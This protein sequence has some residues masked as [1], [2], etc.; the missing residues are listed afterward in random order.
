MATARMAFAFLGEAGLAEVAA[1]TLPGGARLR[2]GRPGGAWVDVVLV[3]RESVTAWRLG[4]HDVPEVLHPGELLA[5]NGTTPNRYFARL[6][7]QSD[8]ADESVDEF[9]LRG[10]AGMLRE[11]GG[12]VLEDHLELF[13]TLRALRSMGLDEWLRRYVPV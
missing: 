11:F 9:I 1:E 6:R 10:Y 4:H 8:R 3:P 12:P 7:R 13:T 5:M 2:F